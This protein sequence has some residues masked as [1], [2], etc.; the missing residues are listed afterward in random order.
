MKVIILENI[1]NLGRKYEVKNVKMG[2]FRNY[3]LPKK[4]AK[5]LDKSSLTWLEKNKEIIQKEREEEMKVINKIA[6]DIKNLNLVIFVKVGG[7]GQ[8]FEKINNTT[9]V[10]ELND[11]I[12][13]KLN[14]K[15]VIVEPIKKIGEYK[16]E[17][18]L[19]N[20]ISTILNLKV[21]NEKLKDKL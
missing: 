13:Y 1:E 18:L 11:L 3:L 20:N 14:K 15:Q 9:I 10:K 4:L 8:L 12:D 6:N 21:E 5:I 17:I 16:I 19:E 2:F 7:K